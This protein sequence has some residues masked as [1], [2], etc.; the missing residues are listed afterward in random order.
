ML[1]KLL[2]V[3]NFPLERF[4]TYLCQCGAVKAV[5]ARASRAGPFR[6]PRNI[7]QIPA[8][9]RLPQAIAYDK[10]LIYKKTKVIRLKGAAATG[11]LIQQHRQL[12]AGCAT[13]SQVSHQEFTGNP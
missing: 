11:L 7:R 9:M 12:Y 2:S 1:N 6:R 13:P 4:Y 3:L 5:S 10:T 8:Q